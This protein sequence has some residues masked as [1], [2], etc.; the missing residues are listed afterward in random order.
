MTHMLSYYISKHQKHATLFNCNNPTEIWKHVLDSPTKTNQDDREIQNK[1]NPKTFRV[2]NPQAKQV[3]LRREKII[4]IKETLDSSR[5]AFSLSSG[6]QMSSTN[7]STGERLRSL[8]EEAMEKGKEG[9]RLAIAFTVS[10]RLPRAARESLL[11]WELKEGG[12]LFI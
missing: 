3:R 5:I 10:S 6:S 8:L 2:H 1:K 12:P 11:K 7:C 9:G 4:I